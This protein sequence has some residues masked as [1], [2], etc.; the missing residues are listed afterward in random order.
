VAQ[1]TRWSKLASLIT[2]SLV[3][4]TGC[5]GGASNQTSSGTRINPNEPIT[6][7][8]WQLFDDDSVWAPIIQ[9]YQRQH[10][11]V[12]IQ[13]T[14]K[15]FADYELDSLD[16]LAARNGPDIWMV[17]SDW[18]AQHVDK[19]APAPHAL[20]EEQGQSYLA[21][22]Q[23]RFPDVV[24]QSGVVGREIYGLPFSVDTLVLYANRDLL[25]DVRRT[26]DN[27]D[28]PA[29]AGGN[30]LRDAPVTWED[31]IRYAKLLEQRDKGRIT[32]AGVALGANNV[33]ESAD[34]LSAL[35]LQAGTQLTS[36]NR[37]SATFNLSQTGAS[38]QAV[39]PG[40]EALQFFRSFSD[41]GSSHSTWPADFP[42]SVDAFKQGKV[43]MIVN[44]GFLRN[45]LAQDAPTLTLQLWPL[46]QIAGAT[47][48]IDYANFWFETVTKSSSHPDV[49][50]DFLN[51]AFSQVG[52]YDQ[53][54]GRP[55]PLRPNADSLP[56]TVVARA[57]AG[58]P[59]EFQKAT[60]RTWY[61]GRRPNKVD[62]IL[63]ELI[64]TVVNGGELGR[65]LDR[66]TEAVTAL[67]A[68]QTPS[69]PPAA[70]SEAPTTS[71]A[72]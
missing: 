46:P 26:L 3:F 49:A 30:D 45:Q 22:Y 10:P 64:Q 36:V 8:M 23:A 68:K 62:G 44:Y 40:K 34:I 57:E 71:S 7:T 31:L 48:A 70:V 35:M 53:A 38:G 13:Y 60:A 14:K 28:D 21:G 20:F 61:K 37:T 1:P 15:T 12:T 18:M 4:L 2:I 24:Y 67:L 6:I 11:N 66:A 42:N 69:E 29:V 27:S 51:F 55:S 17:R 50:W 56:K 65:S 9:D 72:K 33:A 5:F 58:D 32:R 16:S 52:N 63:R 39:T 59:L 47:A 25:N 41:S 54:T 43:A 19:L